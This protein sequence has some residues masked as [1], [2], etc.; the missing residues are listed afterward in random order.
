MPAVIV[1]VEPAVIDWVI[2]NIDDNAEIV[3]TL[4]GWKNKSPH[5]RE[6]EELSKTT[7]I[8]LGYFF[9][10]TPPKEEF[11]LLKY[12]TISSKNIEKPSRNAIDTINQM[13]DIQ[14]WM[15]SYLVDEG[16]ERLRFVGS[17]SVGQDKQAIAQTLRDTLQIN[18][19]WHKQAKNKD[20]AFKFFRRRLNE[21]GIL[22]MMNG[23]VGS[24]NH[25]QLDI[26][27][28][29]AFALSDEYAP[30]IFIN[31]NDSPGAK[32]FSL[33]HEAVHLFFGYDDFYNDRRGNAND[34]A[35]IETICN[36]VAAEIIVP[37]NLFCSEWCRRTEETSIK[38]D[39]LA[40]TF[41]CGVTLI[42][43][44]ARDNNYISKEFYQM[45]SDKAI[46]QFN[47]FRSKRDADGGGDY[48][49]TKATRLDS[50]FVTALD[51]SVREGK[52]QYT[53]AYRLTNSSRNTFSEIVKEF[54]R[55]QTSG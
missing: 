8:P 42:A 52:T 39:L 32:L 15:R 34:V 16:C 13:K 24:N 49:R 55:G 6:I 33:I 2:Q 38:I 37:I 3:N 50:R 20:E 12:R 9:L 45:I 46:E 28:F 51:N 11:P 54:K 29:R 26:E 23:V 1:D 41:R 25:R 14:D 17:V 53:E 35:A 36:A 10:K 5:F 43:R 27:E 47:D 7:H 31:A 18:S 21:I 30:L 19:N 22:V 40:N 4:Y 48:Y 44:R